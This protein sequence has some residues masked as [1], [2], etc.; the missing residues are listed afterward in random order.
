M[1]LAYDGTAD[2]RSHNVVIQILLS[3]VDVAD[4][5]RELYPLQP[6]RSLV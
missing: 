3:L 4:E 2:K 6:G 1:F 5:I